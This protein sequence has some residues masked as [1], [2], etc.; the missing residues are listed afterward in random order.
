MTV[1]S[2][3][4]RIGGK[5][6]GFARL[7]DAGVPVPPWRVLGSDAFESALESSGVRD[8]VLA[9]LTTLERE[10]RGASEEAARRAATTR[11]AAAI[12]SAFDHALSL[13]A[14]LVATLA[15]MA[16]TLA[17][18][19]FAVRSSAVGED[20]DESSWA[21][22]FETVLGP[23]SIDELADAVVRCW[24]SAFSER[25]LYYRAARGIADEPPSMAVIVQ[26]LVPSDA[27]G[28]LF[29]ADPVT[30][31]ATRMRVSACWGLGE[32]LVSGA[33]DADE[34]L[35]DV[36]GAAIES[37]IAR[38]ETRV[39]SDGRG[40]TRSEA[41]P[42]PLRDRA[43]LSQAMLREIARAGRRI[44]EAHGG[45]RDVEWC[46][47][48]GALW[49][50]QAR[51]ITSRLT[52]RIVWDNSNIQ[53][54]YCG[55][56]TP[57]TFSFARATYAAVYQQTMRAVGI[58][59]RTIDEH[60][61]MLG[62]LLGL[63]NG[64]VYYRLENWYRGLLLLP[65]FGRNKADM[66]RMMGVEEPVDF[67][68]DDAPGAAGRLRRAPALARTLVRLLLRFA[69]LG[70]DVPRFLA[71]FDDELREIDRGSLGARS[72]GELLATLDRLRTNCIE[73]WTTPIVNDFAVMMHVGRLRRSIARVAPDVVDE[74][75]QLLLGGAD[76]A[77]SAAPT[78]ALLE[79]AGIARAD[80]GVAAA[81][82]Q[83][84]GASALRA[85]SAANAA[86]A[87]A[88]GELLD[89]YGDRCMGE[90]KLESRT[91]RDDP[92]FIVRVLRNYLTAPAERVR[93]PRSLEDGAS[94]ARELAEA[95]T[96]S[97]LGVARR[98]SFRRTLA[99]ARRAIRAR[100]EMRLARTRLFGVHRDVYRGIGARLHEAGVLDAP[101]DV[102]YLTTDE[103]RACGSPHEAPS[104][105]GLASL[106]RSRREALAR[107]ER[108]AMPNRVVTTTADGEHHAAG[109]EGA[110][111]V[112]IAAPVS[113]SA[114]DDTRSSADDSRLLRGLG[115]S[116]G[117]AEGV[118]RIVRGPGDDLALD[119]HVLVALRTDPGWAPLFP[120][121]S[122]IVVERGSL[123]SHSAVLARELG[124]PAVVG[125]PGVTTML[126]DG[127]RVRVDGAA[128]T[129]E[130]LELSE[131]A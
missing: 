5:A 105:S 8:T 93:D 116:A 37:T 24:R 126:R 11:A 95:G 41:V 122:A 107:Y 68:T 84:E 32:G 128:G 79:L 87:S 104:I 72:L 54:S 27:A 50:L 100:E 109:I 38:K 118:V 42:E 69:T 98:W 64:R 7:A 13:G 91:L 57:L 129:V 124:I 81:L 55:V 21:G 51:P 66:E 2:I 44:A 29:T 111:E 43:V 65:S 4:S 77:V 56:T 88:L 40:G 108:I 114:R 16:R 85:A 113:D 106:V 19:P 115:C 26:R 99:A 121:A 70:R 53:E 82:G 67:V 3:E 35:L 112:E 31:D 14:E 94:A 48:D 23:R 39:V 18:G 36:R 34:Y 74:R 45:P 78:V 49:I 59:E 110:L 90:L 73:R 103:I 52:R 9:C 33:C 130:R 60:R 125:I 17:P 123:L 61:P 92:E 20:D 46:I 80:R 47:A 22:Q 75:M 12:S 15:G 76:V 102:L 83:R 30:G 127:E 131:E 96:A 71:R 63:L 58:P 86:F 62:D 101:D 97:A 6:S 120:S 10:W 119:G 89:R 25:A 1:T 117:I 28:V